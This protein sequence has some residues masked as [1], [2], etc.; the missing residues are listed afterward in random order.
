MGLAEGV[1]SQ[2]RDVGT[3]RTEAQTLV[4]TV[5]G[6]TESG[7]CL[8]QSLASGP[9]LPSSDGSATLGHTPAVS[10]R[11]RPACQPWPSVYPPRKRLFNTH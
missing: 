9:P 8:N 4:G 5:S 7:L 10:D 2:V 1:H 11:V 6:V 3:D